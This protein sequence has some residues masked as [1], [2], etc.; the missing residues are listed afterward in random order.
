MKIAI[1]VDVTRQC[2]AV[3]FLVMVIL[4]SGCWRTTYSV[5]N[6]TGIVTRNNASFIVSHNQRNYLGSS[7]IHFRGQPN[8][9]TYN[10]SLHTSGF[11]STRSY[12]W[13][14]STLHGIFSLSAGIIPLVE[15]TTRDQE[16]LGFLTFEGTPPTRD[17]PLINMRLQH[18]SKFYS[19]WL[20]LPM[21]LAGTDVNKTNIS[22]NRSALHRELRS[23]PEDKLNPFIP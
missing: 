3:I 15:T 1:N 9:Q 20:F 8:T 7:P 5:Q 18:E 10:V 13:G 23:I 22:V 17:Y 11:R 16:L 4:F 12:L 14:S 2:A 21:A 6:N 19:G